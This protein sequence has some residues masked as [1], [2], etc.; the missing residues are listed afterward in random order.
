MGYVS[1]PS[2]QKPREV[3]LTRE[4]L[5]EMKMRGDDGS[6]SGADREIDE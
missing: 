6:P 3:L 5:M 2:G 4:Q 1:E